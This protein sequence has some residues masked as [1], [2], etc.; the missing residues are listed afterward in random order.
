[1]PLGTITS[2]DRVVLALPVLRPV[3]VIVLVELYGLKKGWL[4]RGAVTARLSNTDWNS[5]SR[6]G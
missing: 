2:Q 6:S 3:D 4:I 5:R 1:M